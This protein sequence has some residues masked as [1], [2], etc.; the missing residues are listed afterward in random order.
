M[1]ILA[2]ALIAMLAWAAPTPALASGVPMLDLTEQDC[3]QTRIVPRGSLFRL[4]LPEQGG[5]GFVWEPADLAGTGVEMVE[6]KTAALKEKELVGGPVAKTWLL[7]AGPPGKSSLTLNYRRPWE[8]D[9][10]PARRCI[11]FLDIR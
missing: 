11:I 5:T 6:V 10:P 9:L 8:K 4:T 3:G 2:S 7:R 1:A